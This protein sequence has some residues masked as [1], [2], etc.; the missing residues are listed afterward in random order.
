MRYEQMDDGLVGDY[1]GMADIIQEPT[2]YEQ[3][4]KRSICK[5]CKNKIKC[6]T[7][8]QYESFVPKKR[9]WFK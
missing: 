3:N 4:W 9:K 1:N 5:K 7:G 8:Y 6:L 2:C